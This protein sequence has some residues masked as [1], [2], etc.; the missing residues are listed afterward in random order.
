ML[1]HLCLLKQLLPPIMLPWKTKIIFHLWGYWGPMRTVTDLR[2]LG[3]V[4][5]SPWASVLAA[6]F[7]WLLDTS[8]YDREAVLL[9]ARFQR[10]RFY[11]HVKNRWTGLTLLDVSASLKRGRGGWEDV[12][13]SPHTSLPFLSHVIRRA[14]VGMPLVQGWN[15]V[16]AMQMLS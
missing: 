3:P 2:E 16:P 14:G 11:L 4:E 1:T 5:I 6:Q 8:Q 13:N 15:D 7:W 12:I 9:S 10:D